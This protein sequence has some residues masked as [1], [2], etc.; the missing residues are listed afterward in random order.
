MGIGDKF[1]NK[2]DELKGQAKE[3]Y[4]DAT[5]DQS[6]EAEGKSE[7]AGAKLKQ[8]AENVKDAFKKGTD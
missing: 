4:G 2:S 6:M 3:A 8:G 7:Q 5:D 1:D